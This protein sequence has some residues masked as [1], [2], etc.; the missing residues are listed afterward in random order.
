MV[1]LLLLAALAQ[2]NLIVLSPPDLM[3]KL[4]GTGTNIL[5]D[6]TLSMKASYATFG[7]IPYGQ[8]L[9]GQIY[10]DSDNTLGCTELT[11][12][13]QENPEDPKNVKMA[14]LMRGECNF[15]TKAKNA[16]KAGAALLVIGDHTSNTISHIIMVDDGTDT[17]IQIPSMI[18]GKHHGQMLFEEMNNTDSTLTVLAPFEPAKPSKSAKM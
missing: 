4:N 7:R 12:D 14:L 11:F 18:I 15:M 8:N 6:G 5:D 16:E 13:N 9:T 10:I 17:G 1:K 2:A 3:S